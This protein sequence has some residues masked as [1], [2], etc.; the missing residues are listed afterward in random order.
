MCLSFFLVYECSPARS[1]REEMTVQNER[2]D[3]LA[4]PSGSRKPNATDWV[5][6]EG[7]TQGTKLAGTPSLNRGGEGR[8]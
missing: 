2:R 6:S 7:L 3:F 1:L 8:V 5:D 4:Y